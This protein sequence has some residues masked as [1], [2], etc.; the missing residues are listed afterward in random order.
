MTY[1]FEIKEQWKYY[2]VEELQTDIIA[3]SIRDYKINGWDVFEEWKWI[4]YITNIFWLLSTV[5]N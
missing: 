3:G 5:K 2:G 4:D 1:S